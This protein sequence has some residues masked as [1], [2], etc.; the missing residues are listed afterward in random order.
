MGNEVLALNMSNVDKRILYKAP[1]RILQIGDGNFIRG[2]VDWMIDELNHKTDFKGKIV[3]VQATPRGY[4][5]P[6]LNEQNGLYTLLARGIEE[7]ERVEKV[8]LIQSIQRAINPY[9]DWKEVLKTAEDPHMEFLFSN[10]TEA[11]LSYEK[12]VYARE[13]S[14]MSFPGKVVALLYH[15]YQH[16]EGNGDKGWVLIPCELLEDNGDKLKGICLE[17][18]KDWDLPNEFIHWML[19]ACT[20]CNTLV[21]RIVPG[22]PED[23]ADQLFDRLGYSDRLLTVAEPYYLFVIESEDS[24]IEKKLPFKEAGLNVQFNEIAAFRENKIKLLNAPH[25]IMAIIGILENIESVR[26]VMENETLYCYIKNM[27]VEEIC[28]TLPCDE[29][30]NAQLYIDNVFDRFRNPYLYHRLTDISLNSFSKFLARV[31]PSI[32]TYREKMGQNPRRL[33]FS[34]ASLLVFFEGVVKENGYLVKED[35]KIIKKFQDFYH[36]YNGTKEVIAAFIRQLIREE[37]NSELE[38]LD[39]LSE[40]VAT[41]YIEI[42]KIGIVS[43]IQRIES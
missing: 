3:S 8:Q 36:E 22:Y 1:E 17:I 4:R 30:T 11:G 35:A 28:A 9:S 19:T 37:F 18:I 20:F 39:S 42:K 16:F 40:A 12:E 26:E 34:F 23:E 31:W 14:P 25:T 7:G 21:D 32:E 38:E 2:F 43:A 5:V 29:K 6:V 13:Q 27:L 33:V 24:S 10:T 41:D 15:R